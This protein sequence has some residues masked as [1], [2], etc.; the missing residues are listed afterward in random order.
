MI[1]SLASSR[2]INS[3]VSDSSSEP[4]RLDEWEGWHGLLSAISP[5]D[6]DGYALACIGGTQIEIPA[7]CAQELEERELVGQRIWL[8]NIKGKMRAGVMSP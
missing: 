5:P 6:S 3:S 2:V 8:A 7:G 1:D 4:V